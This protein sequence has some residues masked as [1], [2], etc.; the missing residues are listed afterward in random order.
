MTET[1]FRSLCRKISGALQQPDVESLGEQGHIEIDGVDITLF[2]DELVDPDILFCYVDMGPVA[3]V[4]RAGVYEQLLTMNLLSGARTNGVYALDPG[5]GN[6]LFVV[7]FM[8]PE[9]LDAA[10]LADAFKV[11]ATQTNNFRAMLAPDG[12]DDPDAV[13]ARSA[14][15][16]ASVVNL[17]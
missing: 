11:Y 15:R 1:E 14:D 8:Q 2:F 12:E 13:A 10:Q 17:A 3:A 7:H 16:G 9:R 5:R 4:S 6:A